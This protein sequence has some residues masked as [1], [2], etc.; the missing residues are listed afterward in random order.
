MTEKDT[1]ENIPPEALKGL[2]RLHHEAATHM[3]SV[4]R[5]GAGANPPASVDFGAIGEKIGELTGEVRAI[6]ES[7]NGVEQRMQ[8]RISGTDQNMREGFDRL[9]RR[10][11]KLES[12][13]FAL[14]ITAVAAVVGI[15][16]NI[17]VL[18]AK[19]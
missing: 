1:P 19:T 18:L 17:A 5:T 11:E 12:R 8:G 15:F 9:E 13:N 2:Q 16:G 7:I 14:L 3:M 4:E 10:I 6:R